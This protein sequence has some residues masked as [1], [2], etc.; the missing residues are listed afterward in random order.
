M[1]RPPRRPRMNMRRSQRTV[2]IGLGLAI[3]LSVIAWAAG[4]SIRSPAQVAAETAP[5][6]PS[7]IT[8]P[9]E[10]RVL[11]SEVIVR[12]TVRYGSPQPVVLATS[13]LKQASSGPSSDIVTIRPRRG[14]RVSE[15]AVVMSVSGRPV[16]VLRGAQAS[17]RDIGPG[18]K[19]PDVRQLEAALRRMG[20]LPGPIDGKY[21]GET[22]AAVA[23]WY[24]KS[25]YQPFG[26]TDTQLDQLRAAKAAAASARDAF[27]Q[28]RIAI[29]NTEH[30][31]TP[32]DIAQA[33]I[34]LQTARDAVDTAVHDV[35]AQAQSVTLAT[36]SETR[37]NALADAEVAGKRAAV[38]QAFD[39]LAEAKRNAADATPETAAT[40]S[41]AIR[42]AADGITV[43]QA[44]LN[45]SLASQR[46]T[47]AQGR[48]AVAKAK[49]DVVR[50]R[51]ALP[52]ARRQVVLAQRR[53]RVLLTPGDSSLQRLVAES[54]AA[55]ARQTA[56]DVSRLAGR[57][58]ISV[59]AN[60][61][62]FFSTLPLRVDS[63]RARRGDAVS[64]RVMTVSNSRLAVDSSLALN[65]AKLVKPGA[66]VKIE[67][68]DLGIKASGVVT[69]VADRP[70][71][72]KVDPDR[73]YLAVTPGTAPAQLLG[74]SVKLTI[75]VKSTRQAVLTVPVTALSVGA[76]GS[77]RVQV[78]LPGGQTEYVTVV[79]GLAAKGLVEVRA[80]GGRLAAGG[81]AIDGPRGAP[82]S[83]PP[84]S[85]LGSG[86]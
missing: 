35:A 47:R 57:I 42:Q 45:A 59:P 25:G 61:V 76:D 41:A 5:P 38:N 83:A 15:G 31:A 60:E 22:A 70:G 10:R 26:P 39:T 1:D 71:T 64:G 48:D 51:K 6:T 14:A 77:S 58:G 84:P 73:V 27:L 40:A 80:A 11:S 34:D 72:H 29:Q 54:A 44:D 13:S 32:G 65:D 78:Q 46:A 85:S 53:L 36:L 66:P 43:A 67:E 82:D 79:P 52:T 20:F 16:F 74:T 17:H 8:V 24:E 28:D 55:E 9:V 12:G 86:A 69:Q 18:D 21:D 50:A 30:P 81:P 37:D 75:A 49:A 63:V 4:R 68:P 3:V 2:A 62:L 19:G 7:A 23:S 56:A 33:R